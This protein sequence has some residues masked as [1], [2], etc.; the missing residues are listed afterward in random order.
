M[1]TLSNNRDLYDYL[2]AF[3]AQLRQRGLAD[4]SEIVTFA[5]GQATSSSTEFL[6]ESRMALRRVSNEEKGTLTAEER[7]DV[8]DVLKQ[9]DE[10]LDRR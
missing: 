6:G 3:A 9:L 1:K 4:L 5:S 7:N 2:V 10:A 8:M